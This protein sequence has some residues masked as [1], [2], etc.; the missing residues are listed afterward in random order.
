MTSLRKREGCSRAV[1]IGTLG[2][3]HGLL[4]L[5]DRIGCSIPQH[6]IFGTS[7][8]LALTMMTLCLVVH[9]WALLMSV[10]PK[11]VEDSYLK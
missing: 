1:M 6:V 4:I 8:I 9:T 5:R 10:P 2:R 11:V 7:E 3:L